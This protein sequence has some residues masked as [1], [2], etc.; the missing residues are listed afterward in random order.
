MK[1]HQNVKNICIIEI[2]SQALWG[3]LSVEIKYEGTN[4]GQ[5]PEFSSGVSD[6]LGWVL[7]M[8]RSLVHVLPLLSYRPCLW[9]NRLSLWAYL[10]LRT[11]VLARE[12][13]LLFLAC[14]VLLR[15]HI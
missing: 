12:H 14:S 10:L 11:E 2:N 1:F 3:I 9:A 4:S 8:L 15:A 5:I 6:L 13:N 7:S